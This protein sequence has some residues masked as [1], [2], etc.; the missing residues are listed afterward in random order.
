MPCLLN[1]K[2]VDMRIIAGESKN[3]IIKTKKG[4]ST[5]PTLSNIREALFS[6]IASYIPGAK[7][8]DLF[9]G[10]GI[11]ALEAL[12]RGASKAIMIE[13][14]GEAIKFII[15]NINNL[16]YENKSRAYKND[17]LSA[18]NILGRKEEKFNIIFMDPPYEL[19]I[20]VKVLSS[21]A[22]NNL[23]LADGIII[24]EHYIN[25]KLDDF[26]GLYKKIDERNYRKKILT[27]YALNKN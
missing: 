15:E 22:Q 2:G 1:N 26:V 16:G 10:S 18:L 4:T 17:V 7:I 19:E 24:C 3:R 5:R 9:S 11:I 23:L 14:D 12:S 25:E 21:V 13:K 20:C 8:L 27:F 6:M